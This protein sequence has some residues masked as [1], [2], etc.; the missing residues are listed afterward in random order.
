MRVGEGFGK[1]WFT[2]STRKDRGGLQHVGGGGRCVKH[3]VRV[4]GGGAVRR[5]RGH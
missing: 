2:A 1:G 5:Q 4:Q 3:V